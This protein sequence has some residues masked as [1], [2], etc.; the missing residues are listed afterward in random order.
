MISNLKNLLARK[1][2]LRALVV[3]DLRASDASTRLGW[4]WWIL[5]PL[6]LMFIYWGVFSILSRGRVDYAPYPIFILC[7][8]LPWKHLSVAAGKSASI[9]RVQE[10]L[11]RSVAFPTMVLPISLAI[12]S[13]VY[14]L[15]G[16]GVLVLGA[17]AWENPNHSG[18]WWTLLQSPFLMVFQFCIV[19]GLA[20]MFSTLGV[21]FR[22]FSI[23]MPHLFRLGFYIS[24]GL[25]GAD[26]VHSALV[27]QLGET[28]GS[29]WFDIYMLNPFAI[30]MTAYRDCVFY[31][32]V[33]SAN[34]WAILI[35]EAVVI[36]ISGTGLYRYFD[37]RFVKIL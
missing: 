24:P 36:L 30:L 16:F 18:N 11:L 28:A 17:G 14:F 31:G 23:L 15:I 25:Y 9:L 21:L 10:S 33:V 2:L 7:A 5:D 22:D 12:I 29:Y 19:A 8:L 37:R 26:M 1:D 27:R 6:L 4:L 34:T 32:N 20:L 35:V 3:S 13:F